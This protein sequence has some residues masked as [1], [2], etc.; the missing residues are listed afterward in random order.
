MDTFVIAIAADPASA[1]DDILAQIAADPENAAALL[2]KIKAEVTKPG[3]KVTPEVRDMLNQAEAAV[4]ASSNNDANDNDNGDLIPLSQPGFNN[5]YIV[6]IVVAVVLGVVFVIMYVLYKRHTAEQAERDLA[7]RNA[8]PNAYTNPVYGVAQDNRVSR[9]GSF[10]HDGSYSDP[11][12][13][14][15]GRQSGRRSSLTLS[16]G[17]PKATRRS[18]LGRSDGQAIQSMERTRRSSVTSFC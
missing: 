10:E 18:S 14:V 2:E 9:R 17:S 7:L 5:D 16:N 8:T 12:D 4:A 1:V 15:G 6:V 11:V 13:V 3:E